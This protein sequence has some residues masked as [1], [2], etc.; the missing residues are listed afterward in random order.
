MTVPPL[1]ISRVGVASGVPVLTMGWFGMVLACVST[2]CVQRVSVSP[3]RVNCANCLLLVPDDRYPPPHFFVEHAPV[4][5]R[6]NFLFITCEPFRR[7]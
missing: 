2:R 4:L 5:L 3:V 6:L 1:W 7:C